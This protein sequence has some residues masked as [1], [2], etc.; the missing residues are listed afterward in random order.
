MVRHP[1]VALAW[2]KL[3]AKRRATKGLGE[4]VDNG[5]ICDKAANHGDL[6]TKPMKFGDCFPGFGPNL[7]FDGEIS[8]LLAFRNVIE[9]RPHRMPMRLFKL[10]LYTF[11][12]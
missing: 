3:D 6:D 11:C 4:S 5:A 10:P 12:F 9:N 1:A 2:C 8:N 7:I